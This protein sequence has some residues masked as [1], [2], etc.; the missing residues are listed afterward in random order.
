MAGERSETRKSW[1]GRREKKAL[2]SSRAL[3]P[4]LSLRWLFLLSCASEAVLL[5]HHSCILFAFMLFLYLPIYTRHYFLILFFLFSVFIQL[6]YL[7]R[8]VRPVMT[9]SFRDASPAE[10]TLVSRSGSMR[11]ET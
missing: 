8:R 9:L 10:T 5:P 7:L 4:S 2:L 11:E 6:V 3:S 1:T